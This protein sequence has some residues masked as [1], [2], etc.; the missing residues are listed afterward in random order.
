MKSK[1]R[2]MV[3]KLQGTPYFISEDEKLGKGSYGEVYMAYDKDNP[4]EQ[5]VAKIID[6]HQA[7]NLHSIEA[8]LQ[9][10]KEL[11]RHEN[12]VNCIKSHIESENNLYIIMEYCNGGSLSSYIDNMKLL[13]EE[14]IWDFLYQIC[15][16]YQ[17]L[18]DAN[19]IHRDIK[20]DNILINDGIFKIADFGLSKRVKDPSFVE[21][22]SFK[23]SP[24]YMAPEIVNNK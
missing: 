9:I 22:L 12:L 18:L 7:H 19:L 24:L 21:N 2:V 10:I 5:L 16:G 1:R 17:V 15:K 20:P 6:L 8:E 4:N 13:P 14:K 11:P 23:G 3:K